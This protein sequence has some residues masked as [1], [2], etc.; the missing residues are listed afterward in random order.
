VRTPEKLREV[1]G[2]LD[3]AHAA[4]YQ[5]GYL[6]RGL[7]WCN[8]F[9]TDATSLLGCEVP[10]FLA[11][12]QVAWLSGSGGA[13][14]GWV[15]LAGGPAEAAE[16]AAQGRPVVVGWANEL[17]GNPAGHGHV[18]LAV[19]TPAGSHGLYVAQAGSQCSVSMPLRLAFGARPVRFWVHA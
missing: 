5:P 2:S 14:E 11:N 19:P 10:F 15:E 18:A 17:A 9:L 6:G 16:L 7:T 12:A 1:V 4:K 13:A 8:R 3:P